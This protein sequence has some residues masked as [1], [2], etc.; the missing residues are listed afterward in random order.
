MRPPES[1]SSARVT[2]AIAVATAAV[3]AVLA[4]LRLT[5]GAAPIGG[6]VPARFGADDALPGVPAWLTPLTATLLHANVVHLAFN[7][8]ILAFC[9]RPTEA[10]LGPAGLAILYL[11]GAYAA[12][13]AQYLAD[14]ASA[15]PMVGASGAVSGVLGAYAIL[16]G[17]NRVR[18][19]NSKLALWLNAL[20]LMAA[21]IGL[22][23][24]IGFGISAD[25]VD[26]AIAAHIGGFLVGVAL[27]NPLL[28]LRYRK[29]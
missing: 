3:W 25:G 16:F 1:W 27:A 2:L 9:G 4:L 14:P 17:R 23:L 26:I 24:I 10:V 28:L 22:Q 6:F 15:V 7:L 13:A 11:V 18:V 8:L 19:A 5:E 21:W 29:A 12:A 20:W